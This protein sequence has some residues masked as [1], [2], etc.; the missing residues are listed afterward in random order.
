MKN[1]VYYTVEAERDLDE[2]WN[3]IV[4][5]LQN[6]SAAERIINRFIDSVE[7]LEDFPE[8]GTPLSSIVDLNAGYRFLISGNYLVFYHLNEENIYIDRF[9]YGRRNYLRILLKTFPKSDNDK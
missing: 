1:R 7:R 5:E 2:I 4:S 3:Y 6:P 8:L 9:L